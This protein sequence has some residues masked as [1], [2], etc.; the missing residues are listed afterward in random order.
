MCTHDALQ[1]FSD[2]S[3]M[4]VAVRSFFSDGSLFCLLV[5]IKRVFFAHVRCVHKKMTTGLHV[6]L[7]NLKPDIWFLAGTFDGRKI[8]SFLSEVNF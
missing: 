3:S 4:C 2:F 5:H 6:R 8:G 7:I 1:P